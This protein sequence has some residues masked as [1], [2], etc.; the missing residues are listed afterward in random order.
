MCYCAPWRMHASCKS[1]RSYA[2]EKP[3]QARRAVLDLILSCT[4]ESA[5]SMTMCIS[6]RSR[7]KDPRCR[8]SSC[9]RP[10]V[11]LDQVP[12]VSSCFL[13]WISLFHAT[14]RRRIFGSDLTCIR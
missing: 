14:S 7:S 4:L 10:F 2:S 1:K 3:R 11:D 8:F 6:Y 5:A 12:K 13:R 9:Y